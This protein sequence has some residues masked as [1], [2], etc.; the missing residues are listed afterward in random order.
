MKLIQLGKITAIHG[1]CMDYMKSLPDNAY[2]LAIVDPPYGIGADKPSIKPNKAKRKNGSVSNI[3][4]SNY[5]H[6]NW[7]SKPADKIYFDELMRV[8]KNQ[9]IWGVNYYDYNFKG[10]R[11]VWDKLNGTSDQFGCEIAYCS[12]NNRTD[13]VYFMWAGMMQGL[14]CGREIYKSLIQQGDKSLNEK[15]IHPTQKPVKLYKWL[16]I[17]Y[18]KPGM[19]IL[20]T[21]GGSFSHAIACHDLNFE[22][23]IIEKDKDYFDAAVKRLGWHQRQLK[24]F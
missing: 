16:L 4:Q 12:L 14:Y 9:I 5:K 17:N 8:S 3:A 13:I 11:I 23:T 6:K 7:D 18:A 24:L 22:L 2:D 19:K 10:G 15:R 21:H 20:D 1:D